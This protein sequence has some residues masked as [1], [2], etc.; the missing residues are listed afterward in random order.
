M[1][2]RVDSEPDHFDRLVDFGGYRYYMF[3]DPH[4]PHCRPLPRTPPRAANY[5]AGDRC[6]CPSCASEGWYEQSPACRFWRAGCWLCEGTREWVH[7]LG[8]GRPV[9]LPCEV[10]FDAWPEDVRFFRDALRSPRATARRLRDEA[11]A[12][13][14]TQQPSTAGGDRT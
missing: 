13:W 6:R 9:R 8:P 12:R 5:D 1:T 2:T 11:A 7:F 4:S 14:R 10:C 3:F